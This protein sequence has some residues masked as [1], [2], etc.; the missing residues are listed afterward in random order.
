MKHIH[1]LSGYVIVNLQGSGVDPD[2]KSLE[3]YPDL[4]SGPKR[5]KMAQKNRKQFINFIFEV[6]DFLF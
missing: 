2:S 6:L 3:L 4:P 5:A 1:I